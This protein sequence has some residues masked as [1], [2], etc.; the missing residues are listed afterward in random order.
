VGNAFNPG[1]FTLPLGFLY[2]ILSPSTD[3]L[4]SS[5]LTHPFALAQAPLYWLLHALEGVLCFQ[6]V[7][8]RISTVH[9]G[10]VGMRYA[11][12]PPYALGMHLT[13]FP[14]FISTHSKHSRCLARHPSAPEL[15]RLRPQPNSYLCLAHRT[16]LGQS[17]RIPTLSALRSSLRWTLFDVW[18]RST[19][20]QAVPVQAIEHASSEE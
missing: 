4:Y 7:M 10:W 11:S 5:L 1:N 15:L 18:E 13:C 19:H 12:S 14:A 9:F 2:P 6:H 16:P 17:P 3:P 8:S 20:Y